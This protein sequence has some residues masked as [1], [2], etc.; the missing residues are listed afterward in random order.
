MQCN[1]DAGDYSAHINDKIDNAHGGDLTP[2]PCGNSIKSIPI[3]K[4]QIVEPA[5]SLETHA[6]MQF[7]FKNV[8][9]DA[10]MNSL[11]QFCLEAEQ[12]IV[13]LEPNWPNDVDD[14][15]TTSRKKSYNFLSFDHPG[16]KALAI[17]ILE[18]YSEYAPRPSKDLWVE[19]WLNVPKRSGTSQ[20]FAPRYLAVTW[21]SVRTAVLFMWVRTAKKV[22]PQ[23]WSP[24][25]ICMPH[26]YRLGRLVNAVSHCLQLLPG[27][28]ARKYDQ[29]TWRSLSV[30]NLCGNTANQ[31]NKSE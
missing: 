30:D 13:T 21:A 5:S 16:L 26:L 3:P 24:H 11:A 12:H 17:T 8:G 27:I 23:K 29:T 1:P 28:V 4:R 19:C 2:L 15:P 10:L 6:G 20:A 9:T 18:A 7:V 25:P 22:N 14:H 31:G